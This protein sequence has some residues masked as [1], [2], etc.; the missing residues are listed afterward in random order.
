MALWRRVLAGREGREDAEE[1]VG[2]QG[3]GKPGTGGASHK[4]EIN[5][6][7]TVCPAGRNC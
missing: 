3:R 4:D 2:V 6:R 1:H 7:L 5:R